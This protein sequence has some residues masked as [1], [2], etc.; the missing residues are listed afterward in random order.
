M[1][2]SQ[3]IGKSAYFGPRIVKQTICFSPGIAKTG[4]SEFTVE[5]P[6]A[7]GGVQQRAQ[8]LFEK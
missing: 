7:V 1:Q 3:V 5:T 8:G 2:A 4:L 6:T